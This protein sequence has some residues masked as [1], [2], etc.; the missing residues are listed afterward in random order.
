MRTPGEI[1][2]RYTRRAYLGRWLRCRYPGGDRPRRNA[3]RRT[4]YTAADIR[5]AQQRAREWAYMLNDIQPA[6]R[7]DLADALSGHRSRKSRKA[8]QAMGVE[9]RAFVP[10]KEQSWSEKLAD[11]QPP[12]WGDGLPWYLVPGATAPPVGPIKF[13]QDTIYSAAT[14]PAGVM[15]PKGEVWTEEQAWPK[16]KK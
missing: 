10:V 13:A 14:L 8:M 16:G 12:I 2:T 9:P 4:W 7:R 3:V 11:L 5:K 1:V 6:L 15:I